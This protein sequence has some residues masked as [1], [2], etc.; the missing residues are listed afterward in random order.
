M[1]L[2]AQMGLSCRI[3][4][5]MQHGWN[6]GIADSRNQEEPMMGDQRGSLGL[7]I[8]RSTSAPPA[9]SSGANATSDLSGIVSCFFLPSLPLHWC[10]DTSNSFFAS[11]GKLRPQCL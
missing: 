9:S 8:E 10:S 4:N 1:G 11:L 7:F 3:G 2:D 6:N 5:N